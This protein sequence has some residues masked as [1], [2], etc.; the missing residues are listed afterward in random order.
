MLNACSNS[1]YS[2]CGDIIMNFYCIYFTACMHD[3]LIPQPPPPPPPSS[4]GIIPMSQCH[5]EILAVSWCSPFDCMDFLLQTTKAPIMCT[6]QL[7]LTPSGLNSLPLWPP[8]THTSSD[9]PTW[10]PSFPSSVK[11]ACYNHPSWN[12]SYDMTKDPP[13]YHTYSQFWIEKGQLEF[14]QWSTVWSRMNLTSVI[15]IWHQYLKSITNQ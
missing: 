11:Q 6:N 12:I 7:T 13:K 3:Q 9:M 1:K 15:T 2:S 14:W 10:T 5:T 4:C 8:S